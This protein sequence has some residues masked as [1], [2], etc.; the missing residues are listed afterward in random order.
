MVAN[1]EFGGILEE[2][3]R[4]LFEDIIQI[5]IRRAKG[6]YHENLSKDRQVL[7]QW[8]TPR[9]PENG[10]R[11]LTTQQ[12]RLRELRITRFLDFVHRPVLW[13]LENNVSETGS[14]SVVR[15]AGEIYSVVSV[16]KS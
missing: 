16:R 4:S 8:L 1:H 12:Q 13:E 14:V 15:W 10:A 6:S 2:R 9:T 5:F 3:Y 11:M 7:G